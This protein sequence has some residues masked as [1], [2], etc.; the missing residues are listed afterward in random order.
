LSDAQAVLAQADPQTMTPLTEGYHYHVVRSSYGGVEQRWVLIHS[1]PRQPQA[2][3]TVDKQLLKHSEQEVK[4]FKQL[5]RTAF[6]CAADAQQALATFA[7]GLQATFLAQST[8]RPTP[9][10]DKRGRPGQ[11]APPDQVVYQL[12]GA[13]AMRIAARQARIDQQ[14]CFI[15]ATNELDDTLF[16]PQEL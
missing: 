8:V 6:A 11:G 16:P 12:D 4:A 7:Q 3:R 9:R 10:Y 14:S 2:Q 5:C 1:E 15:L 13:L